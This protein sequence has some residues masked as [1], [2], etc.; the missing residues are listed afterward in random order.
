MTIWL[1]FHAGAPRD[2]RK[3]QGRADSWT[4]VATLILQARPRVEVADT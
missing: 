2:I 4:G 1:T 3:E